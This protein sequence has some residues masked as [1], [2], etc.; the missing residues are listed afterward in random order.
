VFAVGDVFVECPLCEYSAEQFAPFG[1]GERNRPNRQCPSCLS[2]ERHRL[3]WL[4]FRDR[5]DLLTAPYRLLHVAPEQI[6][7]SRLRPLPNIDYLSAD[8]DNAHA[9]VKMDLTDIDMPDGS[10][11]VVYASHVLE[12][13]PDDVQAMSEILRILRPGGWAILQV[14]IGGLTTREEVIEDDAERSAAYGQPDHVR[15]YGRDGVYADRLR[16]VGFDVQIIEFARE[17]GAE[18]ID[19]YRLTANE[20]IYCCVKPVSSDLAHRA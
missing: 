19:R 11:D 1:Y 15:M 2:L 8:L 3:M 6:F 7:E 10:F 5:T 12:H 20:D 13:I 16:S 9:M 17:L 4:Y 14:P 18:L